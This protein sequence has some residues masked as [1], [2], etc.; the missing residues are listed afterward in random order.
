MS[1]RVN[2]FSQ[3][4]EVCLNWRWINVQE[5]SKVSMDSIAM[6]TMPSEFSNRNYV[7]MCAELTPAE[8]HTWALSL[9]DAYRM[10]AVRGGL[11][12]IGTSAGMQGSEA[13]GTALTWWTH[14]MSTG[15][16]VTVDCSHW[17]SVLRS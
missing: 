2:L 4:S 10:S 12:I 15:G 1:K 6:R 7:S 13:G 16:L 9:H 14:E 17:A 5:H 8:Q 3:I 11:P